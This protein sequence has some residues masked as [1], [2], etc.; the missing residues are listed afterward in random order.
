MTGSDVAAYIAGSAIL[1]VTT[2]LVWFVWYC[3]RK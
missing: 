3:S 2:I 1:L